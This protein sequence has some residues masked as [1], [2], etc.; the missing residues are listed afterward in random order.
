MVFF[1]IVESRSFWYFFF[2]KWLVF[3]FCGSYYRRFY[4]R[5]RKNVPEEGTP[6]LMVSNH[7]N[8]LIDALGILFSL[9]L[10]YKVVFLARADVF[11]KKMVAKILNFCKIMPIYRQ[12]DGKDNLGENAAIFDESA[13]LIKMGFPVTLFPEG[14]HQEGHYLG[15]IKKGFARIAFDAAEKNGFPENLMVVPVGNHYSDYFS[16]RADMCISYGEPIPLSRYYPLYHENPAKALNQLTEDLRPAI[17]NLMLDIP[18]R[19]NYELY[20]RL[21]EVV[22]GAICGKEGLRSSYLPHQL[23]ADR[24]FADRIEQTS[25]EEM[26]RVRQDTREY[27]AAVDSEGIPLSSVEKPLSW[28]GFIWNILVLLLGLPFAVYGLVFTGLPVYLGR[29]KSKQFSIRIK[30]KMLRSSF[31]F[32][33][34]QILMQAAFYF[35]YIVLYW[36]FFDSF[37]CF[38]GF[39]ASCVLTRMIWQDYLHM[40]SRMLKRMRACFLSTQVRKLQPSLLRLQKWAI[41]E[42]Y[43]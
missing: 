39:M 2:R 42:H 10:R 30:N 33:F 4:V 28:I 31:D 35:V 21:R 23:E 41:G 34:T 25:E 22:R 7:Q 14:Q 8:G 19:D 43:L 38:V 18:D 12:R 1:K 32:V 3:I 11:K 37:I 9:P 16:N 13:K 5:N 40:A 36:I 15:P 24:K 20:D 17:R 29:R 26:S 27:L 6:I